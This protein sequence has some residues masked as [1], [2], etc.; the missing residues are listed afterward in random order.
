VGTLTSPASYSTS[1]AQTTFTAGSLSLAANSTYWVVLQA[2]SGEFDWAWTS[3]NTGSGVGFQDTY[4]ES[5]DA[6]AS[7][8]TVNTD[9]VQF[10]VSALS[11]VPEPGSLALVGAAVAGFLA[12][13]RCR[14][15]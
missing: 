13:R 6:G 2:N 14:S 7:W 15:R 1:L 10:S 3:D 8:F 11:P 9:P 5:P 4:G 12:H